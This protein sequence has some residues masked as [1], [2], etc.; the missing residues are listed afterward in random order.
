MRRTAMAMGAVALMILAGALPAAAQP[1][2]SF[3]T[4]E[5]S[6][7]DTAT[8]KLVVS[9][10]EEPFKGVN[11]KF[12]L[13]AGVTVIGMEPGDLLSAAFTVD[14]HSFVDDGT[15]I[16]TALG[17]SL[18]ETIGVDP[19]SLLHFTIEVTDDPILAGLGEADPVVRPVAILGS[20]MV[21]LDAETALVHTTLEGS[22]TIHAQGDPSLLV[23]PAS[24][25]VPP[26]QG[27]TSLAVSNTGT[28]DIL[29]NATVTTGSD[30]LTIASGASGLDDGVVSLNYARNLRL[31]ER[32][33]TVVIDG[34]EME[35]SPV[36]VDVVQ[37][38]MA[39]AVDDD[40]D[41]LPDLWEEEYFGDTGSTSAEDDPD[42]DGLT[43]AEEAA[44]GSNPTS[45]DS[46]S[47]GMSDGWEVAHGLNPTDGTDAEADSDGDGVSNLEEYENGTDPQDFTD[48]EGEGEVGNASG[49]L[50]EQFDDA[51]TDG[52]A[53]LSFTEAETALPGLTQEDFDLL[54]SNGDGYLTRDELE[55]TPPCGCDALSSKSSA[56]RKSLGDWLWLG[57]GL[58]VLLAS[59]RSMASG[60]KR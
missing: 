13:P 8:L 41:G 53:R 32:T 15:T 47:D 25:T 60:R 52:D 22:I 5:A 9:G 26:E 2:L 45:D 30:W 18:D 59:R 23:L 3:E 56:W 12:S 42:G 19:G 6:L 51:D 37:A 58:A 21:A 1:Q 4:A 17:Y 28:G 40:G 57:A 44:L 43:N 39:A 49:T 48:G 31:A 55:D 38:S 34:G 16:Q 20:G 7:D 46:D 10:A 11:V 54:D 27:T 29:W 35:G 36:L 24:L 14:T 33:A 50:L